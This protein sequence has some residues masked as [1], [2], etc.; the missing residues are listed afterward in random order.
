MGQ[1]LTAYARRLAISNGHQ[2][3]REHIITADG[4]FD[5]QEVVARVFPSVQVVGKG[6]GGH[7]LHRMDLVLCYDGSKFWR[8]E[9]QQK[10]WFLVE[11]SFLSKWQ[12]LKIA[13]IQVRCKYRFPFYL[14][15]IPLFGRIL[16]AA[17]DVALA[18]KRF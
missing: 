6:V 4:I 18:N 17:G 2:T 10:N 14:L 9:E 11:E 1:R 3:T 7:A 15:L 12:R 8:S 16:D 5:P 13:M